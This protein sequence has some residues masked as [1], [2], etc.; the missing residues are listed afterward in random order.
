MERDDLLLR[1][2]AEGATKSAALAERTG[3]SPA[4]VGRG[5]RRLIASGHVFSP[6]RGVYRL[7]SS[8]EHVLASPGRGAAPAVPAPQAAP[9]PTEQPSSPARAEGG[10]SLPGW[11]V[12]GALVVLGVGAIALRA[13]VARSSAATPPAVVPPSPAAWP[14]NGQSW[15]W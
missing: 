10:V 5:L 3:L 15:N 9:E 13:L 6:A 14:D 11:L 4:S 7:T 1:A 8:G 12:G 2:I